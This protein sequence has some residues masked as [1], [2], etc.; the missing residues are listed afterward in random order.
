MVYLE[1]KKS[2]AWQFTQASW[3]AA[4]RSQLHSPQPLATLCDLQVL[5]AFVLRR[6][7]EVP[8]QHRAVRAPRGHGQ[9][10]ESGRRQ[11]VRVG[12]REPKPQQKAKA[13]AP[14]SLILDSARRAFGCRSNRRVKKPWKIVTMN[15][16]NKTSS[17]SN[18][19]AP[20]RLNLS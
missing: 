14:S 17:I 2:L 15:R 16:A 9:R 6:R 4:R 10:P 7:P 19:K 18:V 8:R 1:S 5:E 20:H 3:Q 11:E 12:G 13:S